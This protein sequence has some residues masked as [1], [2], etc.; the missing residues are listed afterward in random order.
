MNREDMLQV[1]II[2]SA[3]GI[4]GEVN[5]FPT[6]DDVTRFK[7]LKT[8]YYFVKDE[9]RELN[10][11]QVKFFKN[12]V[13]IKFKE[14]PDRNEAEKMR[15]ISLLVDREHAVKLEADE[16]FIADLIGLT[17]KEN[18]SGCVIGKLTDVL[19]TGAN[20]V[21]EVT[22]DGD[23][24]YE[25]KKPKAKMVYIPAIKECV[26]RVVLEEKAMYINIM[27]GLID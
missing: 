17:V 15:K 10:V 14:I 6:T 2:T 8:V 22:F 23:F 13:I 4:K 24:V 5:V 1:G 11:S 3:H 9:M 19:Q 27:P 20:D 21:Y 7:K 26:Q 16:F 12:M 25:E 18:A